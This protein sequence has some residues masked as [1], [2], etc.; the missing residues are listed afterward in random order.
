MIYFIETSHS[1]YPVAAD[2]LQAAQLAVAEIDGTA[3]SSQN[4]L[5][6]GLGFTMVEAEATGFLG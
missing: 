6:G 1:V 2:S 4:P 5:F 3:V